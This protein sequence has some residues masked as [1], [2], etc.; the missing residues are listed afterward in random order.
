MYDIESLRHLVARPRITLTFNVT[1]QEAL[2]IRDAQDRYARGYGFDVKDFDQALRQT[3]D[4]AIVDR[5]RDAYYINLNICFNRE[6]IPDDQRFSN[7]I[8]T[9]DR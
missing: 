2:A 6:S 5:L 1:P 7:D 9:K 8:P 4:D 3:F